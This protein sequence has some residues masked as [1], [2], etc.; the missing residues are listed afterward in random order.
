MVAMVHFA[1]APFQENASRGIENH[2]SRSPLLPVVVLT[3]ATIVLGSCAMPEPKPPP[4]EPTTPV[5]EPSEADVE[6]FLRSDDV[7][8]AA[9][10]YGELA[11]SAPPPLRSEYLLDAVALL[12]DHDQ[13]V[14][15]Q[16][17]LERIDR[18]ALTPQQTTRWALL[19]AQ[20]ALRSGRA[21]DALSL[22]P[23]ERPEMTLAERAALLELRAQAF[24]ELGRI[25]DALRA[26]ILLEPMLDNIE[27][28]EANYQ[29]I[30]Q[31]LGQPGL[32]DLAA[33]RQFPYGQVFHGWVALAEAV[34]G[35]RLEQTSVGTAVNQWLL[36]YPAHPAADSFANQ[37]LDTMFADRRYPHQIALLLPLHGRLRP[38]SEAIRDGFLSAYFLAQNQESRPDVRI[39]DVD[40]DPQRFW[41]TYNRALADGAKLLVG[42][43]SKPAVNLLAARESLPMPVLSLNYSDPDA[44]NIPP[45]ELF[46]FGLL[47]EDEAHQSAQFIV[48]NGYFRAAAIIP[49]GPWGQRLLVAFK[50]GLEQRGGQLVAHVVYAAERNDFSVPIQRL[51]SLQLSK[52]RRGTLQKS[53][54]E[55]L[56]FEPRRR[57]DIDVIFIAAAPKN[58]RLLKPQLSFHHAADIPV[59]ATSHAFTGVRDIRADKDM[60]GL[61]YLDIPLVLDSSTDAQMLR[62]QVRTHW[63]ENAQRYIRLFALGVDAYN[64]I[65][66]LEKLRNSP[67]LR[68]PGLTGELFVDTGRRVHRRLRWGFFEKG[69][70]QSLEL[71]DTDH[72]ASESSALTLE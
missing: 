26:R 47:P 66:D 2:V 5:R 65:P 67:D 28:I 72:A 6:L 25:V 31:L 42:P 56:K 32:L 48:E 11:K 39:Y 23:T 9:G 7:L 46:Q 8:G 62:E 16:A 10:V 60:D 3:I 35:A 63:P 41:E 21:A 4:S 14:P 53:L 57:E 24:T 68:L 70:P 69:E 19:N 43:L 29:Q 40:E 49:Q 61:V 64:L 36:T 22:L 51:L 38:I 17:R 59:Y 20:L 34:R 1:P 15:A 13:I 54:G 58:A 18:D 33:Y 55:E 45:M 44:E 50:E 71:P 30:W 27:A 12:V 52:S 37:L